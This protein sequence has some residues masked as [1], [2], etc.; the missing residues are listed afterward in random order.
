MERAGEREGVW[1]SVSGEEMREGGKKGGRE[2]RREG[3]HEGGVRGRV[4]EYV[5]G[6]MERGKQEF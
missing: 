6:R 5:L 1:V 2:G 3:V 4:C